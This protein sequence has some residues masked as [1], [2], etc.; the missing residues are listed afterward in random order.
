MHTLAKPSVRPFVARFDLKLLVTAT[1]FTSLYAAVIGYFSL[2]DVYDRHFFDS[3]YSPIYNLVRTLFA[4]YL[5]WIVYFSGYVTLRRIAP[6]GTQSL[7][8]LER[9]TVGFFVGAA[10]WTFVMLALGYAYLYYPLVAVGLTVPIVLLSSRH[11][12][13]T[14]GDIRDAVSRFYANHSPAAAVMVTASAAVLAY[15]AILLFLVKGLYPGGAH[16][17]FNQYFYFYTSGIRDHNIWPSSVWYNYFYSKGIGLFFLG[18]L[19][20]DPL[21]PSLATCCFVVA[22]SCALFLLVRS[23]RAETLWPWIA[24]ILFFALYIHTPGY[25]YGWGQFQKQHELTSAILIAILW[26]STKIVNSS[27]RPRQLWFCACALLA[28]VVAFIMTVVSGL[29]GIF[30]L[31]TA[32]ACRVVGNR[33]DA[34][35][36]FALAVV[37]GIG[38]S[39]VLVLNYAT[40]GMP[41]DQGLNWFWPI[42]DLRRVNGWGNI[43]DVNFLCSF[44]NW[45]LGEQDTLVQQRNGLIYEGGG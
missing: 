44:R 45:Q 24:V 26:T 16:D 1:L 20:T 4:A 15:F 32:A 12:V 14:G 38:L 42:I 5:F 8:P 39:L 25:G 3:A 34:K 41:L 9:L 21:A 27:G 37:A 18:M 29:V 23:I 30:L 36:M 40:T 11:L 33:K 35:S 13:S 7:A 2:V 10:L 17:Y 22:A 6:A 31:L 43:I 19:L 28:F